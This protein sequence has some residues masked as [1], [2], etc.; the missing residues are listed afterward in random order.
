[1]RSRYAS[2]NRGKTIMRHDHATPRDPTAARHAAGAAA[3]R[4]DPYLAIHKALR[5]LHARMLLRL[6]QMDPD[7]DQETQAVTAELRQLLAIGDGHLRTENAFFHPAM[8]S[9]A[10]GSTQ[11][12]AG[13]H[14]SHGAAFERL[15]AACDEVER[16]RGAVRAAAALSLYRRFALFMAEDLVH[17]HAEE[18]ENNAVLWA[19]HT[20]GEIQA[21]V[22]RIV[23]SVPPEKHAFLV[24]WMLTANAPCERLKLLDGVRRGTPAEQL[25]QVLERLLAHLPG[26]ERGKLAAALA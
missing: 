7:D 3:G 2:D 17:M 13:D 1:V 14:L 9:R 15:L 22:E 18:T 4:F 11:R 24:R 12:T 23:A 6:G 8:E 20:D 5:A 10:P 16:A 21:I 26:A 19:T 25:P